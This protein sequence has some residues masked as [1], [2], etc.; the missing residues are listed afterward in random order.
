MKKDASALFPSADIA[1]ELPRFYLLCCSGGGQ[2]GD[3]GV[4]GMA[5]F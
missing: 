4:D 1:Y 3:S 5:F 2:Y